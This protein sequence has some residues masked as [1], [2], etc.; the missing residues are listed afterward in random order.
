MRNRGF[1]GDVTA[2]V[3]DRLHQVSLGQPGQV[4]LLIGTNDLAFGIAEADIAANVGRIVDEI[5]QKSPEAQIYVQ[6]VLPRAVEYRDR[7]ES[8]NQRLQT[9]IGEGAVW[10]DLYPE[11]LDTDG[12]IKDAFSND[13]L[14]LNGSGYMVWRELIEDY[15][16]N[17]VHPVLR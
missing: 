14:H 9:N 13:E 7:I 10:I 4:F 15:V 8:L 2:G 17:P 3:L 1:G 16:L 11:F 12:S 5:H 6:S